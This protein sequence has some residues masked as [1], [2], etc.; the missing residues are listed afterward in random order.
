M[1]FTAFGEDF[2]LDLIPTE[3][4]FSPE[5]LVEYVSKD[6]NVNKKPLQVDDCFYHGYVISH[7]ASVTAVSLCNNV[8]VRIVISEN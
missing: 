2:H 6:G 8:V 5:L 1:T 3:R 7:N 4:F